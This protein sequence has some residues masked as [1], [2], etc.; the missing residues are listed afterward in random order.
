MSYAAAELL[1]FKARTIAEY[2]EAY[3]YALIGSYPVFKSTYRRDMTG[4]THD[5]FKWRQDRKPTDYQD[6][7][8]GL[9]GEG[10]KTCIQSLHG[11]GKSTTLSW[12]ILWYSLTR[13]GDPVSD[14]KLPITASV[15]RQLQ[16]YLFPEV[17]KW[18]KLLRFEKVGRA[19]FN[20]RTE[21]QKLELVLETGKAATMASTN[22]GLI[23]GAH[24]DNM[25]FAYDEA[26]LI[27]AATFDAS[28]GAFAGAGA[29]T[30]REAI[31]VAASTPGEPTGRFYDICSGAP[32]LRSWKLYRITLEQAVRAGRVSNEW[33]EE[34][35]ELWGEES[36]LFRNKVIGEFAAQGTNAVIP[37][38]WVEEAHLRFDEYCKRTEEGRVTPD[39]DPSLLP[40]LRAIGGDIADG[41]GDNSV[42]AP[43]YVDENIEIIAHLDGWVAKPK[44]QIRTARKI[45]GVYDDAGDYKHEEC[46]IV[47]DA[48]GVGAGVHS[49]LDDAGYPSYAFVGS[50]GTSVTDASGKIGYR[51]MRTLAYFHTREKLNPERPGGSKIALPRHPKLTRDL[52]TPTYKEIAGGKYALETKADI[53]KRQDGESTDYGDAVTQALLWDMLDAERARSW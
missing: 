11:T 48:N 19:P 46:L 21:L 6:D 53:G 25:G 17:R 36:P 5:C 12:F 15:W 8:T 40:P 14:W 51:N 4:F 31:A 29:D 42:I 24:A 22:P 27:P 28:N 20:E 18:A 23:E 9:I 32:G 41:G 33:V 3:Y 7:I 1:A 39:I 30:G 2:G 44:D 26:K 10:G 35:R 16:H 37:L 45:A 52:T 49:W 43:L 47:V 13:D 50:E 34:M 38:A